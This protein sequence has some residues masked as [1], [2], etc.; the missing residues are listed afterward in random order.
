MIVIGA[1]DVIIVDG[2]EIV[3]SNIMDIKQGG[4]IA[5]ENVRIHSLVDGYGYNFKK[6]RLVIPPPDKSEIID[7]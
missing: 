2:S 3:H 6:S 5:V 4:P 1:G 7:D